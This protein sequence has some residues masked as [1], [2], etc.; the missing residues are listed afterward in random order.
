MRRAIVIALLLPWSLGAALILGVKSGDVMRGRLFQQRPE[1]PPPP[2]EAPALPTPEPRC[3]VGQIKLGAQPVYHRP[4]EWWLYVTPYDINGREISTRECLEIGAP[5]PSP[6]WTITGG[7]KQ[8]AGAIAVDE[9][10][11]AGTFTGPRGVYAITATVL[12]HPASKTVTIT[13]S[14]PPLPRGKDEVSLWRPQP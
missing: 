9:F 2:T 5:I 8:D 3:T 11:W 4:W 13:R 1:L 6:V 10:E 12:G 14:P 7:P